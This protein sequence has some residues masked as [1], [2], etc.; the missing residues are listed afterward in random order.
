MQLLQCCELTDTGW[1]VAEASPQVK[2]CEGLELMQPWATGCR[3]VSRSSKAKVL[4][5]GEPAQVLKGL[6]F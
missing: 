1:D 3:P 4:Q 6:C 5:P 2:L